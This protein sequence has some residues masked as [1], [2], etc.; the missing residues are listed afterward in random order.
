ML[1]GTEN[2]I[3]YASL[4][5]SLFFEVF[6][7][8]TYLEKRSD[9][10]YESKAQK[11]LNWWPS[12]T[13]IVPCW[14]EEHTILKT[15]FSLLKL[16][17]PKKKLRILIVDDGS[18]DKTLNVLAR[19]KNNPQV[20]VYSKENGGKHTAV[21]FGLEKTTSDLVG[22]LDADS[23]VDPEALVRI[24]RHFENPDIMAVTPAIKVH[25][26]KGLLQLIQRVEYGWGIFLRKMLS[27][28]GA[29]YVTPGPFSIF[30]TEV[31]QKLGGYKHAHLTED[32]EMA[33]RMQKHHYQIVN[34]H[35]AHVYTVAPSTMPAL[36]KQRV[37]WTYGFL[38]NVIDYKFLLFK[39]EYG[40]IGLYILPMAALSV[41]S[42]LYFAGVFV[43]YTGKS[44]IDQWEK[45]RTVGIEFTW[46]NLF[47][48]D[49]FFVDTG[50]PMFLVLVLGALSILMLI[51]SRILAEGRFRFSLDLIY[52]LTLYVFIVPLWLSRAV[53]TTV[54]G[55]K[56]SWR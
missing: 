6:L 22:C 23:F 43:W 7:L 28:L 44:V 36:Y 41:F 2:V 32:F 11:R 25:N 3:I 26:P 1:F 38:N 46:A 48:F 33:L 10:A 50:S 21:N 18:T 47:N 53:Y 39:K 4:F 51:I 35:D 12:V 34:A 27:Y 42:A 24:V 37:R 56:V 30:R 9:I 13:I 8:I 45:V 19:F 55:K 31:F 20:E 15:I 29:I 52:F 14:N 54:F 16:N 49:W 17:Y 5:V 40:N